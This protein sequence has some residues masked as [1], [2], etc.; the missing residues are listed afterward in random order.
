MGPD[1]GLGVM[2]FTFASTDLPGWLVEPN[3]QP[4]WEWGFRLMPFQLGAMAAS[5]TG[6][7][8]SRK[9][10]IFLRAC[11][12]YQ[13]EVTFFFSYEYSSYLFLVSA[14]LEY[15]IPCFCF[16]LGLSLPVRCAF[17]YSFFFLSRT[18]FELRALP[19]SFESCPGLFFIWL[20]F[21]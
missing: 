11:S 3:G 9:S 21:S 10:V 6:E 7:K 18:G 13:Y 8:L 16:R 20:F 14:C 4:L 12:I 5:Y 15:L 17:F 19:L 2:W 1:T